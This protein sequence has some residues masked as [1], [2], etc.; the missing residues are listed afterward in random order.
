MSNFSID[1]LNAIR[2]SLENIYINDEKGN[3]IIKEYGFND[4]QLKI[5]NEMILHS[6]RL[7]HLYATGEI[8][9]EADS[10][11]AP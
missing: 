3:S 10:P 9:L 2:E 7:Y 4:A 5:I 8:V 1:S 11:K 6:I